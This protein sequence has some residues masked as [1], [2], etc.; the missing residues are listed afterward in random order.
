MNKSKTSKEWEQN[1]S[2]VPTRG[3]IITYSDLNAIKI[4]DGITQLDKLPFS[5]NSIYSDC[6]PSFILKSYSGVKFYQLFFF[7]PIEEDKNYSLKLELLILGKSYDEPLK[8][9]ISANGNKTYRIDKFNIY[10]S[11][12]NVFN[13][14]NFKGYYFF[15]AKRKENQG[16]L[17]CQQPS[18][19]DISIYINMLSADNVSLQWIVQEFAGWPQN[20]IQEVLPQQTRGLACLNEDAGAAGNPIYLRNG[21][22]LPCSFTIGTDVPE[23]AIFTDT[24]YKTSLFL[25]EKENPSFEVRDNDQSNDSMIQLIGKN[26]LHIKSNNRQI[27]FS[28]PDDTKERHYTPIGNL[29]KQIIK[30][31]N[32]KFISSVNYLKDEKGHIIELDFQE[33]E[34]PKLKDLKTTSQQKDTKLY[35]LG[36]EDQSDEG[37]S[38]YSNSKAYIDQEGNVFSGGNKTI[39]FKAEKGNNQKPVY[40]N[41]SGELLECKQFAGGTSVK[42]NGQDQS[43]KI[44]SFYAPQELGKK[45]QV[46]RSDGEKVF[47]GEDNNTEYIFENKNAKLAWGEEAT[48]ATIGNTDIKIKMPEGYSEATEEKSGLMDFNDKKLLRELSESVQKLP[49]QT[50]FSE[51]FSNENNV[52]RLNTCNG[53]KKNGAKIEL[54]LQNAKPLTDNIYPVGLNKEGNLVVSLPKAEERSLKELG[55]IGGVDI[56][57]NSTISFNS[58]IN[59]KQVCEIECEIQEMR[60]AKA[61]EAGAAGLVPAPAANQHYLFLR[62]DGSWA[63]PED[64]L[65]TLPPATKTELG[66]VIIGNNIT[67]NKGVIYLTSNNIINALGYEPMSKIDYINYSKEFN[68]LT[69]GNSL[70]ADNGQIVL[71]SYNN[72][73]KNDKFV[74][75]NGKSEKERENIFSIK[76]DGS[77]VNLNSGYS[78]YFDFIDPS[79][80]NMV[81]YHCL[82]VSIKAG[83]KIAISNAQDCADGIIVEKSALIGGGNSSGVLVGILGRFIVRDN[84]SCYPGGF[85]KCADGGIATLSAEPG[86]RVL[87]RI[88]DNHIQILFK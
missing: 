54:A 3:D 26:G 50:K 48:I 15:D 37:I 64:T 80:M 10:H 6:Q 88:D 71:G 58:K 14:K 5:F 28:A 46:L 31:G 74:I 83:G 47:W 70:I 8:L 51:E 62:G 40:L 29:A 33:S 82:F 67:N 19:E 20:A 69:I 9:F 77:M 59:D 63:K 84:G 25:E 60:P 12:E 27:I 56:K 30:G 43:G 34:L 2:F 81:D 35:L 32:D 55:G 13:P 53:I 18:Y 16:E 24:H 65:Y 78:E 66:G 11:G 17:W 21:K 72:F 36:A 76:N 85:C 49:P 87:S 73:N 44:V 22:F 57:S 1:A 4:G 52:V 7:Q 61:G 86:W 79:S 23:N 45:N 42:L 38:P 68:F 75:G 39:T 41:D